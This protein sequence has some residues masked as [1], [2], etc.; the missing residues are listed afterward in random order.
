MRNY[1]EA[2]ASLA[3]FAKLAIR[4]SGKLACPES[5]LA[6]PLNAFGVHGSLKLELF[7]T[8]NC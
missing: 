6:P 4:A 5:M 7:S 2:V 3:C 1:L 8:G